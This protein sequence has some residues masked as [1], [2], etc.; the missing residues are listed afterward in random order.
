VTYSLG[1]DLGTT[2]AAAAVARP[3]GPEMVT[4]GEHSV[5]VPAV[6]H[7]TADGA[8]VTGDAAERRAVTHPHLVAR[9]VKRALADPEPILLGGRPYPASALLAAELRDVVR[10]VVDAEGGPPQRTVL[11]HPAHWGPHRC[12]LFAQVA[13]AAGLDGP[14]TVTEPEAAVHHA[15]SGRLREGEVV[16]VHDL[17]G[18]SFD[19]TIVRWW[20]QA[21][22]I[23]GRPDGIERLGGVDLDE[24]ILS[25][26]DESTGGALAGLDPADAR[27][28]AAVARLR[29]ECVLA[30]EAL[31]LDTE[32]VIPVF[33]P[34]RQIDVRLTRA[35]F[36]EMIRPAVEAT[37]ATLART[38]RSA[39]L[40]ASDLSAVLL[41][42]GSSR[43]P[44]IAEAV[45]RELGRP[46]LNQAHPKYAL[47]LGA[48][49]IAA[50]RPA[51]A[52]PAG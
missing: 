40:T 17:G 44:L 15:L 2:F 45:A 42:G 41:V 39:G 31:S 12:E 43:I 23:L 33:L 1:V 36:Q 30:K 10:T 24:A 11:T 9:A 38:L 14:R 35:D 50:A 20:A 5:V 13:A 29:Q 46:V 19:A 3:T 16:A 28:A 7:R 37:V 49:S 32:T 52:R 51:S 22:E 6:V 48:A 18:G 4:L 47:A 26:V 8:L 27:A 25:Y 21:Y 34:G